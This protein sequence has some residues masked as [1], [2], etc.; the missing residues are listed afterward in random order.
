MGVI[1]DENE[2]AAD[3]GTGV[4]SRRVS[5]TRIFEKDESVRVMPVVVR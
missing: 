3:S 4:L 2:W 5:R 1:S